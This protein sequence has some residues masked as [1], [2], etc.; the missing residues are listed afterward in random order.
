MSPRRSLIVTLQPSLLDYDPRSGTRVVERAKQ[1]RFLNGRCEVPVEWMPLVEASAAWNGGRNTPRTV[2]LAD[3]LLGDADGPVAIRGA[4]TAPVRRADNPPSPD[5]DDLG[6]RV[7]SE[8]IAGGEVKDLLTAM[9]WESANKKR[10]TVLQ[11]LASKLADGGVEDEVPAG[12]I[13]ESFEAEA[14]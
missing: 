3:D 2:Y 1:L 12:P 11:A 7:L 5:W 13:A 8:K 6:A 9:A 14:A 4:V 10:K